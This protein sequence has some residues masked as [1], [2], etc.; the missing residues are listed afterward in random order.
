[1]L[2]VT[3]ESWDELKVE[4]LD[5]RGG[6]N[7]IEMGEQGSEKDLGRESGV[8]EN[9]FASVSASVFEG[10]GELDFSGG[11][12]VVM[13]SVAEGLQEPFGHEE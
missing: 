13:K 6:F 3:R 1:M 2:S 9:K 5:G 12:L 4:F 8:G 7:G 11:A 10:E